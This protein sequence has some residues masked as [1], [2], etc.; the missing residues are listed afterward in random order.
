M[1]HHLNLGEEAWNETLKTKFPPCVQEPLVSR[2]STTSSESY[3]RSLS[4]KS[5]VSK[6]LN[7]ILS[8]VN[9]GCLHCNVDITKLA[10]NVLA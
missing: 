2:L 4:L 9:P 7:E 8:P 1:H 6:I 5:V 3:K 10:L